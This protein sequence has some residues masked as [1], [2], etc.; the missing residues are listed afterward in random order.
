MGSWLPVF[1]LSRGVRLPYLS[2]DGSSPELGWELSAISVRGFSRTHRSSI[3]HPLRRSHLSWDGRELSAIST[4]G[5]SRNSLEPTDHPLRR[6][7]LSWG[8]RAQCDFCSREIGVGVGSRLSC[9]PV[10]RREGTL[11]IWGLRR[12][13]GGRPPRNG[14]PPETKSWLRPWYRNR[15]TFVRTTGDLPIA[16]GL[17]SMD[18][19]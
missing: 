11:V 17:R 14:C 4:R 10:E 15:T 12:K 1:P 13:I 5:F 2:W 8:E 9:L 18:V 6:S 19:T 3:I 16:G 7:H